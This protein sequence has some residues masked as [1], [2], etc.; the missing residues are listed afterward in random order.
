M[1]QSVPIHQRND[2]IVRNRTGINNLHNLQESLRRSLLGTQR[3]RLV[4]FTAVIFILVAILIISLATTLTRKTKPNDFT[5]T[6]ITS[7]TSTS[8]ISISSLF[9]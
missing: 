4:F 1:M 8:K 2:M 5:T 9:F 6:T 7:T 3:R